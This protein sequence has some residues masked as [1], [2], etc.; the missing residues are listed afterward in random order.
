MYSVL[1]CLSRAHLLTHEL[2]KCRWLKEIIDVRIFT[3]LYNIVCCLT[4]CIQYHLMHKHA[5]FY[6]Y[7]IILL[8]CVYMSPMHISYAVHVY[9]VCVC[10]QLV[11]LHV[12]AVQW[13]LYSVIACGSPA[14]CCDMWLHNCRVHCI[15]LAAKVAGCYNDN[16]R[17]VPLCSVCDIVRV[18]F[19][20]SSATG[21]GTH[22]A[23]EGRSQGGR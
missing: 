6:L 23:S 22:L 4:S 14:S 10:V 11:M 9:I 13:C 7:D 1:P 20:L 17:G 2:V 12:A 19:C 3:Y 16:S 21:P 8:L 15:F 5:A 18:C